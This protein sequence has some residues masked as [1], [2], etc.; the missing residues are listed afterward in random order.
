MKKKIMTIVGARPQF[1]KAGVVSKVLQ[2]KFANQLEEIIIHTGQHYDTNMSEV[3]FEQLKLPHPQKNLN[4]GSGS[5][6]EQT[7]TMIIH[8]EKEMLKKKPDIV[9]VYGDT[10]STLAGALA[11]SK[12]HIPVA[13]V[14]AGLR[15]FNRMMPE[16]INRIMVDHVSGLLFAPTNTAVKNLKDEG[17]QKNV[18]LTGDVMYDSAL[19][20]AGKAEKNIQFLNKFSIEN[21]LESQKFFLATVHRAENTNNQSKLEQII[22]AF[23]NLPFKVVWPVHPRMRKILEAKPGFK[24]PNILFIEPL[25]Y[26]DMIL[27]LKNCRMVLTD[28][29]GIQKES[30]F[31]NVSTMVVSNLPPL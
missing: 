13:H 17:I 31:F 1:I 30:L 10:N 27:F 7:G 21:Q 18:I 29:G 2:N 12:I 16:E 3:F 5:H 8:L 23:E 26:L 20:C 19:Y 6:A 14:E 25:P 28:S 15:S 22:S 9:L 24:A 11:A 4:I